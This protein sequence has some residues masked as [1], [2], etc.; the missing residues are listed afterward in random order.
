M[1]HHIIK[2][3]SQEKFVFTG[4]AKM[5]AIGLFL[6]GAILAGVGAMDVKNNWDSIGQHAT[7][8]VH[9]EEAAETHED[10]GHNDHHATLADAN[11]HAE[12]GHTETA[13]GEE[14]HGDH[15]APTWMNRV[16]ANL[17]MNSYYF[18]L[19]SVAAIFFIA[20]NYVANAGWAVM[21]KRI[22]EAQ[23]S[24]LLVGSILLF[25]IIFLFR[26]II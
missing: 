7:E 5:V 14:A 22:M 20:V 15:H 1:G 3:V 26:L 12:D 4:R 24:Y 21:L 11:P 9:T 17:L 16:W 13:H 2:E 18:W 10:A 23:S 6:I 8:D 19:F 25:T